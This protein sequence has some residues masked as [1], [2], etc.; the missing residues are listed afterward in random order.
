MH[1]CAQALAPFVDWSLPEVLDGRRG[2]RLDRVE[3]V[4]PALWAVMVSLAELWRP[5]GSPRRRWWAIPRAR[6]PRPVWPARCRWRT[7]R[8]W[9]RC[10]AGRLATL[11]G[12]RGDGRRCRCRRGG[13]RAA[14]RV[15]RPAGGGRGQRAR[16]GGV[17][18]GEPSGAGGAGGEPPPAACRPAGS[19]WTT[20]SHSAQVEDLRERLSATSPRSHPRSAPVA[21]Y[22]TVTGSAGGHRGLDADYWYRNM[23]QTV[24]FEQAVRGAGDA[25][26]SGVRGV[27]PPPGADPG[28]RRD[29]HRGAADP[30]RGIPTLGR[31]HGGLQRFWTSAGQAHHGC[32]GR[33][34]GGVHRGRGSGCSCRRMRSSGA[35]LAG[36]GR[37][38]PRMRAFGVAWGRASVA[39]GG[40]EQPDSGGVVLTGRSALGDQPWLADHAVAGV[41]LFPGAGFVELAI[42]AGDEVGCCGGGRIG[43][44][45]PVGGAGT[46]RECRFRWWSA[47]AVE[48]GQR[49]ISV[50]SRGTQPGF[51]M[52]AAR[53]RHTG[54][55]PGRIGS[56]FVGMAP[57][58]ATA[59]DCPTPTSGWLSGATT[60]ARCSKACK[61]CGG[62]DMKSSPKSL[63]PRTPV[64]TSAGSG[65][66]PGTARR[67]PPRG[68]ITSR[69]RGQPHRAAILLGRGVVARC[70]RYLDPG[71]H[72][73]DRRTH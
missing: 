69:G 56:R 68:G 48:S 1:R 13:G 41:V 6:S 18:S 10:A 9:W 7:G 59:V 24:Q 43:A 44:F 70:R 2:S 49:A 60:T 38:A 8:G 53:R 65:H 4:Q 14:G 46:R 62:A 22:S 61:R 30:G 33:L 40:G 36:G 12:R 16:H 57:P 11:A 66:T 73:P 21:F 25:G 28:H 51:G 45:S 27:Q 42:R 71:P 37:R 20:P 64:C 63:S 47:L 5:T 23:R 35:V 52:D 58:G 26:V 55:G 54:C 31:D 29:H 67:G 15:G 17:V 19:P 72:R 50:Y 34:A 32:R 39:G 3:V